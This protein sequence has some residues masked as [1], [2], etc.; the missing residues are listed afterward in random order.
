V[1][2]L[3]HCTFF[4]YF[5]TGFT[6][7][8]ALPYMETNMNNQEIKVKN[9]KKIEMVFIIVDTLGYCFQG[10]ENIQIRKLI[11]FY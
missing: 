11:C 10:S 9:G 2:R 5:I 6:V 7:Q 1:S 8:A 4:G 3:F